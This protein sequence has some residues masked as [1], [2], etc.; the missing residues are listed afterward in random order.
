MR[1]AKVSPGRSNTGSRFTERRDVNVTASGSTSD[2][3]YV[4]LDTTCGDRAT[5]RALRTGPVS[6]RG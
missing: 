2:Y 6:S 3:F 5:E 4:A 1:L